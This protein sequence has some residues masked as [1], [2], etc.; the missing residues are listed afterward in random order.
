MLGAESDIEP[1]RGQF[2]D[3][4]RDV[5]SHAPKMLTAVVVLRECDPVEHRRGDRPKSAEQVQRDAGRGAIRDRPD[6]LGDAVC[7]NVA[8]KALVGLVNAEQAVDVPV[9]VVAA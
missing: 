1:A 9:P 4:A 3:R 2:N 6:G 5:G 8:G 7:P